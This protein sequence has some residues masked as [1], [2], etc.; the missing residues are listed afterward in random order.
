MAK[1]TTDFVCIAV[2]GP[3]VDGRV[4]EPQWLLD[5]AETYNPATY[6]AKL[7]PEHER[8]LSYGR[9]LELKSETQGE[10]VKLYA[11]FEPNGYYLWANSQ[12]QQEFFSI[13]PE[14]DFAKTGK[15]YLVGL[16]V[17]DSPA[18]LGTSHLHFSR[19]RNPLFPGAAVN[20]AELTPGQN[21]Q[22]GFTSFWNKRFGKNAYSEDKKQM[23]EN[24]MDEVMALLGEMNDKIDAIGNDVT[25]ILEAQ[26]FNENSDEKEENNCS[27]ES[28]TSDDPEKK[29]EKDEDFKKLFAQ[30]ETL[31]KEVQGMNSR[32]SKAQAGTKYNSNSVQNG[33]RVI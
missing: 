4:I 9:V 15:C 30:V 28:G 19:R 26:G 11:R 33:R 18:S 17:T 24:F 25:S 23:D 5:M 31:T 32:F 6:T 2:S 20:F 21:K 10:T 8:W 7:W 27:D 29:D 16:G 3:T 14:P 22:G 1:L 13:E 12:G